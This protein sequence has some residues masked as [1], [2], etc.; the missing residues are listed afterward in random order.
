MCW[1]SEK[2]MCGGDWRWLVCSLGVVL[3]R[4]S[5]CSDGVSVGKRAS[6]ARCV[7]R[8]LL[9][10]VRGMQTPRLRVLDLR[11]AVAV[12]CTLFYLKA[13]NKI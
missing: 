1:V 4:A 8:R 13:G 7:G 3:R 5:G 11:F 9:L 10:L 6:C 2:C 12:L